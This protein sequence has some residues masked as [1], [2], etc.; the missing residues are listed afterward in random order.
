[1]TGRITSRASRRRDCVLFVFDCPWPGA[2][3]LCVG[4]SRASY[5]Y[6]KQK[7]H[8]GLGSLGAPHGFV[9]G[10]QPACLKAWDAHVAS[11]LARTDHF[12]CGGDPGALR[13]LGRDCSLLAVLAAVYC[14][15]CVVVLSL[16]GAQEEPIGSPMTSPNK[17][18]GA[19]AGGR[20]VFC[21]PASWTARIARFRRWA[22][23]Q[24]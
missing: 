5:E 17:I 23:P 9:V 11:V 24:S 1:L 16:A 6:R 3:A 13:L 7:D 12:G 2:A 20:R 4:P 19:N 15:L 21:F 10:R 8:L 14:C 22:V 18:A